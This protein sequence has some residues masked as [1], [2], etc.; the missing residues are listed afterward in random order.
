MD[1]AGEKCARGRVP[2]AISSDKIELYI[3]LIF[4]IG[5]NYMFTS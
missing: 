5:P 1:E 4:T 2:E 3:W